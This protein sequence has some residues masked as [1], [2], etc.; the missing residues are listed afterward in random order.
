M[1][2][3]LT[4]SMFSL[5]LTC[6]L[7]ANAEGENAELKAVNDEVQKRVTVLQD[8]YNIIVTQADENNIKKQV[9]VEQLKSDHSGSSAREKVDLAIKTFEIEDQTVQ[10]DIYIEYFGG[11]G[12]GAR[13]PE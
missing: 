7:F 12:G 3:L 1:K 10:R 8:E 9:I 5:F 2:T 11:G 13:P 4:A 6:S